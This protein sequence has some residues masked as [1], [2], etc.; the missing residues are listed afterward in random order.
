MSNIFN[1]LQV[2]FLHSERN[3][4]VLRAR[5]RMYAC[6]HVRMCVCT[7]VHMYV[8]MHVRVYVCMNVCMYVYMYT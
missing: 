8:R 7:Y 4:P 1:R 2:F 3:V 5:V 6:T